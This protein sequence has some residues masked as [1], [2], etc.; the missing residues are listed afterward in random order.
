MWGIA[1]Q[2]GSRGQAAVAFLGTLPALLAATVIL[3]QAAVIGYAAWSAAGAARAGAR[4]ALV[5]E[6]VQPAVR[7]ALPG[8]LAARSKVELAGDEGV[9]LVEVRA[10]RLLPLL[11]AV[12]V[13]GRS[14]LDP[15]ADLVSG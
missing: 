13:S 5:G 15:E 8:V 12:E 11:P 3:A 4:A 2:D 6:S 1:A 14:A 7:A 10:P 9:V